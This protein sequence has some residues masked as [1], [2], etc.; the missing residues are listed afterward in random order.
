MWRLADVSHRR[1]AIL[2]RAR[3][4][5]ARHDELALAVG[6]DAHDRRGLVGEDRRKE[7]QVAVRSCRAKQIANRR[8]ALGQAVEI[9]HSHPAGRDHP[10][11]PV[12]AFAP[13]ERR[14]HPQR[15]RPQ[16]SRQHQLQR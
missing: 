11:R 6:A 9:A 15:T 3:R 13:L 12:L 16:R 7:R 5:P 2:T 10:R 4:A 1:A 8:L 14:A